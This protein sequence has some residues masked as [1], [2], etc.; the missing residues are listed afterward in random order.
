MAVTY[1]VSRMASREAIPD[2]HRIWADSLRDAGDVEERLRWYAQAPTAC[3]HVFVLAAH[4]STL[5]NR[6]VGTAGLEIRAFALAGRELRVALGCNLA[7]EPAHR[8]LFPGLRL[9]REVQRATTAELDLAYNFPNERAQ[10]LFVRAGYHELG[11]MPRYVRILRHATYVSRVVPVT[12]VASGAGAAID[13]VVGARY[14]LRHRRAARA[15]E[16]VWL[17]D[18][19]ARF[20]ALWERA[21][22]EYVLVGR[23]DA[24]WLRWRYL[25]FPRSRARIA[26]LV[27]HG[28]GADV[29]A[30]ALVT[31]RDG[32]AHVRDLFGSI[33]DLDPLLALL[34]RELRGRGATSASFGYL[35][36]DGVVA[37]LDAHGFRP[38]PTSR[39]VFVAA[40][41][42]LSVKERAIATSPTA[43]HLT[44]FDEDS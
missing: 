11:R 15:L 34:T 41:A 5:P 6:I 35:G 7:V 16:L 31:E 22:H 33:G 8:T 9:L 20:D 32:V 2:L 38:R 10:P 37:L 25:V 28:P 3:D 23:R 14:A 18:V 21:R 12:A 39:R 1:S 19:D 43:W 30:Y 4:E 17:D 27:E 26:A 44:E 24:S 36:S 13:L 40:G 29:R 42:A